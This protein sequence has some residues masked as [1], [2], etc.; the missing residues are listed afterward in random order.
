VLS[1][2]VL[3]LISLVLI[4]AGNIFFWSGFHNIDIAWNDR[5]YEMICEKN[6]YE[7]TIGN[8]TFGI[9]EAY[10]DGINRLFI[11]YFLL[12]AGSV[13]FGVLTKL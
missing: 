8:K 7:T 13:L 2:F 1:R 6:F 12:I 9:T 3:L 11:S 5:Y 10:L 4:I